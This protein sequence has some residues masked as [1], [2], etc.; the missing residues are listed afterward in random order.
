[1]EL[2]KSP[3][4]VESIMRQVEAELSPILDEKE[5]E[6]VFKNTTQR[7]R[8]YVDELRLIQVLINLIGNASKFSANNSR[9]EVIIDEKDDDII[10]SVIDEGIG[11]SREDMSKLFQPFP[12]IHIPNV[13]HGSGLG[14][15]VCNGIVKLHNG[16]IWAESAGWGKGSAF[17][18]TI[19]LN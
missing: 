19:P 1:M 17:S 2:N 10:F 18:F 14:L 5:Q 3:V 8:V 15:S 16:E 6:I 4:P 12:D 13:S 11:L 9:I 7:L